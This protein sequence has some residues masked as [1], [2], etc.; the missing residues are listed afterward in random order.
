M[1]VPAKICK[2]QAELL[3]PC[4]CKKFVESL[5]RVLHFFKLGIRIQKL[6]RFASK[7]L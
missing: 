1:R 6:G 2:E 7:V 3:V 4:C 5:E